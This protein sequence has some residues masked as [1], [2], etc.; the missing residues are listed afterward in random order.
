MEALPATSSVTNN[1]GLSQD[2]AVLVFTSVYTYI[3]VTSL[4]GLRMSVKAGLKSPGRHK[5]ILDALR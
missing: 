3:R 1:V 5:Q 4:R 2:E